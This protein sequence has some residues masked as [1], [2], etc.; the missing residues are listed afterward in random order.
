MKTW[1]DE[2]REAME[3]FAHYSTMSDSVVQQFPETNAVWEPIEVPVQILANRLARRI[4]YAWW[5]RHDGG[6]S[7][8][9]PRGHEFGL[10][11]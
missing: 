7:Y 2:Y 1:S 3:K 10:I 9:A 8:N 5:D 4:V 6:S 11:W